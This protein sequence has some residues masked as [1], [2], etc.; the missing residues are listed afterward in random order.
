[1]RAFSI[2]HLLVALFM[3]LFVVGR[4][5]AQGD[6]VEELQK[7][8]TVWGVEMNRVETGWTI[9]VVRDGSGK[10]CHGLSDDDCATFPEGTVDF[11]NLLGA[12][13]YRELADPKDP[14][15]VV[16]N[17][18][19]GWDP[20]NPMP[21]MLKEMAKDWDE[22]VRA[23]QPHLHAK[24]PGRIMKLMKAYPLAKNLPQI[25]VEKGGPAPG[26]PILRPLGH[27]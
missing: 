17:F 4:L 3:G 5:S 11:I 20:E 23:I 2:S 22:T 21:P 1:M 8:W 27:K 6:P 26:C 7:K 15:R 13:K 12:A 14:D 19:R 24:N 10:V 25:T 16:A 9:I 18:R